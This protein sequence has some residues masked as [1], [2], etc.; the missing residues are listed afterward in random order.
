MRNDN[1]KGFSMVELIVILAIMGIIIG[2]LGVSTNYIGT[3]QARA[4]ANSIKTSIGQNKIQTMGKYESFLYIYKGSDG[5]SYQETWRKSGADDPVRENREVL[6]KKKPTVAY[7]IKGDSTAHEIDGTAGNALFIT[8]DRAN[9]KEL[10]GKSL[11][12]GSTD[13]DGNSLDTMS[14]VLCEKIIVSYGTKEY[15]I[16]IVPETGKI[17][18]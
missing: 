10:A 9:G 17:S 4:L 16:T 14:T 6:G 5:K 3:S 12:A 1:N 18:L 2:M 13:E 8:F 7:Y 15:K 11:P